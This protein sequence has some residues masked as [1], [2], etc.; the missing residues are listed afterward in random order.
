MGGA[1]K[2]VERFVDIDWNGTE[3]YM[4]IIIGLRSAQDGVRESCIALDVESESLLG[5]RCGWRT[6]LYVSVSCLRYQQ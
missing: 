2:R 1:S 5:G 4:Q 3:W 6:C